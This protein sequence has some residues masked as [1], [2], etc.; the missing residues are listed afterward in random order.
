MIWSLAL[1]IPILVAHSYFI[2]L[3]TYV[4]RVDVVINSIAFILVGGEMIVGALTLSQ[5][6]LAS[7]KF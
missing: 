3:Q 6:F 5:L 1:G 2:S 7:R 4:L